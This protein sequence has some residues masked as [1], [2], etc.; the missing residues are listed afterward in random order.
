M[1]SI[2][3]SLCIPTMDRFDTFLKSYIQN[4]L[5]YLEKNIIDELVICDEN[6]E[7]YE[8]IKTYFSEALTTYPTFRIYKNDSV[9]TVVTEFNPIISIQ[10][11]TDLENNI[12]ESLLREKNVTIKIPLLVY[13]CGVFVFFSFVFTLL[14]LVLKLI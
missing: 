13:L 5:S 7:D 10:Q 3:I 8:K 12:S 9:E 2:K 6:G 14:V 1:E 4:Y 11:T